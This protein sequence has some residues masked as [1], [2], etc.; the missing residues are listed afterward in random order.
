MNTVQ[1]KHPINSIDLCAQ[2]VRVSPQG[3]LRLATIAVAR[4]KWDCE[5]MLREVQDSAQHGNPYLGISAA[6]RLAFAAADLTFALR[7]LNGFESFANGERAELVV[8][9]QAETKGTP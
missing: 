8:H 1:P 7:F 2:E 6:E 5:N 4:S 3:L 9:P